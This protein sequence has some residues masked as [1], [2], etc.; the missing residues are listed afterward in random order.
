VLV[1]ALGEDVMVTSGIKTFHFDQVEVSSVAWRTAD[2]GAAMWQAV[3]MEN[4]PPERP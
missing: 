3:K 4:V 2:G 1:D